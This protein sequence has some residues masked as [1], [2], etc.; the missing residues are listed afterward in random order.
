MS[1]GGKTTR[2]STSPLSDSND[3]LQNALPHKVARG[4]SGAL[5]ESFSASLH[6]SAGRNWRLRGSAI[7]IALAVTSFVLFS[8]L[9]STP[10]KGEALAAE[11]PEAFN[12]RVM[13]IA[14]NEFASLNLQKTE[15]PLLFTCEGGKLSLDNL[16]KVITKETDRGTED[17]EI[18]RFFASIAEMKE[19]QAASTAIPWNEVKTRLRPQIFPSNFLKQSKK[20][21]VS[22]PLKFSKKLLEGFVI[23]SKN[24]FQYV[25]PK[26]LTNWKVDIDEVSRCAYENLGRVSQ[27]LKI[28]INE[29]GGKDAKGKYVTISIPDGYAAARILLPDIRKRLQKDLGDRCYIAIPN[30]DFLIGWSPDFTHKEKFVAQVRKDYQSRHHPLTPQ[31]YELDDSNLSTVAMED[32]SAEAS[33]TPARSRRQR[34]HR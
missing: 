22:R 8:S 21:I 11:D 25:T 14:T 33:E 15:N 17:E 16:Y 3:D 30:R 20:V 26:H 13:E 1:P 4:S 23:D 28:E 2:M 7:V 29:A 9:T 19:V 32:G 24:T 5:R 34:R 27:D 31:V 10:V 6:K 12:A 18:R